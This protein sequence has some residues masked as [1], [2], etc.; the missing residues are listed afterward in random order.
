MKSLLAL[1]LLLF[2][3]YAI[4]QTKVGGIVVDIEGDPVAFANVVFKNSTEG[5]V[6]NQDGLFYLETEESY[7]GIRN[8]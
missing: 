1:L 3:L 7:E 4:G 5:T 2:P 6:T 8:R